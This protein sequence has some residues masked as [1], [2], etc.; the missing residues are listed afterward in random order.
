MFVKILVGTTKGLL[1]YTR[2]ATQWQLDQVD[3]QG[4]P[5]S[6]I[7]VDQ[8]SEQI[9]IGLP[10]KH[11]G[12]KLFYSP[13]LGRHWQERSVPKYPLEAEIRPGKPAGL[14][15]IW[16]GLYQPELERLWIGT[17]PGGLFMSPD[18]GKTFHLNEALWYHPSRVPHWFGGGRNQAGIHCILSESTNPRQIYVGVSCGGVFR[19]D[20]GGRSWMG[21]NA[22]LRADYLPDPRAE[23]GHDP[24]AMLICDSQ[25]SVVWQ[26]NHCGVFR[27]EDYG[28]QW[29]DVTPGDEYGRY[30]FP[31]AID[32]SNPDRAWIIPAESDEQRVAKDQKLTVCYTEN[33]GS[34]WVKLTQGLPQKDCFDLVFR[35]A[36]ARQNNYLSFG[37]TNG[38]LYVSET[39]GFSWDI[40]SN[41]LPPI[42]SIYFLE[43]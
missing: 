36:L 10:P 9:W 5:V 3:F 7:C 21:K 17:E 38:N 37:T 34:T 31:I 16:S 4:L 8:A 42:H 27:S 35:H 11:W 13:D 18:H 26:Q 20:D 40:I 22:G 19:S 24:H 15:L 41:H 33:A 12:P 28:E 29:Q 43:A 2:S 32:P 30:G 6:M 1:T 25:N 14:K 23:F 39:D